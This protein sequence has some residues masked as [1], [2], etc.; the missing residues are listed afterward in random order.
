M[1][2]HSNYTFNISIIM[3]NVKE[4]IK[5]IFTEIVKTLKD[6]PN[7]KYLLLS[8]GMEDC[9]D[10]D[11][12]NDTTFDLDAN[13]SEFT[14][15]LIRLAIMYYLYNNPE[16]NFD[17]N[18]FELGNVFT[19]SGGV[20]HEGIITSIKK[21]IEHKTDFLF[22]FLPIVGSS[23]WYTL[24]IS[25]DHKRLIIINPLNKSDE[26]E[27]R[28]IYKIMHKLCEELN[29][30]YSIYFENAGIQTSGKSCGESTLLIFFALLTNSANG[31]KNLV[32]HLHKD[33]PIDNIYDIKEVVNGHFCVCD[34]C[35]DGRNT[36]NLIRTNY[37]GCKKCKG[38]SQSDKTCCTY[39]KLEFNDNTCEIVCY[40][41]SVN[42]KKMEQ[43]FR[44]NLLNAIENCNLEFPNKTCI[45]K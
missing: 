16:L 11:M 39:C 28:Y 19:F 33:Y 45:K 2:N 30:N 32:K 15:D 12:N 24:C 41:S 31:Y 34:K 6:I 20:F 9:N 44:T 26:K 8:T 7:Y 38:L 21:S 10:Y 14:S 43:G 22:P 36:F 13:L 23:H 27:A 17:L 35:L 40:D 37:F 29:V 3:T 5:T 25:P 1:L 42:R 4:R 18:L